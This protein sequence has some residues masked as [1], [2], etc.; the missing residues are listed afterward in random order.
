[1]TEQNDTRIQQKVKKIYSRTVIVAGTIMGFALC[2][3]LFTIGTLLDHG[4]N[5]VLWLEFITSILFIFGLIYL[6]RLS[7]FITRILLSGNSDCRRM[8]KNMTVA[9]IERVQ[10]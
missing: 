5:A 2:V 3:F 6:K 1:M 10:Q 4:Y 7:L 8:F 9:D